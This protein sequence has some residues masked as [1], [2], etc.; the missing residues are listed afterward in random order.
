MP[1]FEPDRKKR[2]NPQLHAAIAPED[3]ALP[4]LRLHQ[5]KAQGSTRGEVRRMSRATPNT[6]DRSASG[7]AVGTRHA[8]RAGARSM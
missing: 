3:M 6:F 1:A 8:A 5:L 4:G 2:S 7:V